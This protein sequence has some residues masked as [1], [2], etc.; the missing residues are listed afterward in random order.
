MGWIK[1]KVRGVLRALVLAAV[2]SVVIAI[3]DAMLNPDNEGSV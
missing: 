3:L 1:R 2:A